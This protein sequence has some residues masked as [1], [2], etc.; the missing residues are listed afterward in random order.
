[1]G[2]VFIFS[3]SFEVGLLMSSNENAIVVDSV[4]KIFKVYGQP[5][6]R[7]LQIIL[8]RL[9][10]F[11]GLKPLD[12]FTPI[13][14]L[15]NVSIKVKRGQTV[16]IVGRNGSGKSTLLQIIT[17]TLNSS[18]GSVTTAGRVSALLELGSGFNPDYTGKENI[19]MNASILGLS[20]KEI[21][22]IYDEIVAFADIGAFIDQPVKIYS[23]GMMMRVAFA[24]AIHVRPN[25]LIIDEALSVG[26]E[27]FSR[28]CFAK[29]EEIKKGGATIL[30]VSHSG[31]LVTQLCDH[32][33]LLEHGQKIMEGEPKKV[34]NI[35]QKLIYSPSIELSELLNSPEQEN[36]D[37]DVENSVQEE[38]AQVSEVNESFDP[39][40]IPKSTIS[41]EF[42]G[43]RIDNIKLTT[44]RN[45]EVNNIVR[46]RKY[47]YSFDVTF[48]ADAQGVGFGMLIKSQT[49][50]EFGGMTTDKSHPLDGETFNKNQHVSVAFEFECNLNAGVYFLNSGVQG[51]IDNTKSYLHRVVDASCF[52]VI[53]EGSS[54]MTGMVDFKCTNTTTE[55]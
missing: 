40:L 35:Y 46:G 47:R 16:G 25:L 9:R 26:D 27:L 51:L 48:L 42:A 7:L 32:A 34:L 29:I 37:D 3:K 30:F 1:M 49:G 11:F 23:S 10:K 24:V 53:D 21:A 18:S 44:L 54:T 39:N 2:S 28:K 52:R 13:Q 38:S 19:M 43:A 14:A 15:A 20:P 8:P 33:I 36:S 12:Y 31:G 5:H 17:G 6:H 55:T 41:Y 22:D 50:L 45:D 4:S